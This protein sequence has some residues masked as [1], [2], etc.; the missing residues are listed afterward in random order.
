MFRN[1]SKIWERIRKKGRK[2]YIYKAWI[3][4]SAGL[5]FL[6]ILNEIPDRNTPFYLWPVFITFIFIGGYLF[7]RLSWNIAE[8]RYFKDTQKRSKQI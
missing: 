2:P 4:F 3:Q 1:E 6:L 5:I 7:A 8:K